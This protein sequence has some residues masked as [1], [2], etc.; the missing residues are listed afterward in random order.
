MS[1]RRSSQKNL[2]RRADAAERAA[3]REAMSH[4]ERRAKDLATFEKHGG[5]RAFGD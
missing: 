1:S 5:H 2:K 3:A 4:D